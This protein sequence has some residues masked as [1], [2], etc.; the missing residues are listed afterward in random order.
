MA[1]PRM[2]QIPF[3]PGLDKESGAMV[4]RPG[5]MLDLRNVY[6][7]EGSLVVRD[8][9]EK[10]I[11]F[12]DFV[13]GE[14]ATHI[15]AGI[16]IRSERIGIVVSFYEPTG[17]VTI[18]RVDGTA[19]YGIPLGNWPYDVAV[20]GTET[21]GWPTEE[22]PKIVL[23]EIFGTVYFAHDERYASRRAPTWVY[24]PFFEFSDEYGL[25][26]LKVA[27]LAD[28]NLTAEEV[29]QLPIYDAANPPP[30]WQDQITAS[31]ARFRGVTRH[32]DYLVGWGWGTILEARPELVRISYPGE[33]RRFHADHYFIAGDRRDPVVNCKTARKTLL[34]FK[35]T[36]THR[37]KGYSRAT[38]GIEP[39]DNLY[40][41]LS[42]RLARTVTGE[43]FFWSAEGPRVGGDTGPSQKIHLPLDLGGF[44]PATLVERTDFEDG[45]C[46]YIDEVELLYFGFGRRLYVLS[47]RNRQDPRWT[48]WELARKAYTGFRLYG[49]GGGAPPEG[50]PEIASATV[51]TPVACQWPQLTVLIDN[52]NQTGEEYVQL[53][54]RKSGPVVSKSSVLAAS[55]YNDT[56][57][58]G[59]PDDWTVDVTGVVGGSGFTSVSGL[60]GT[61]IT[62]AGS[63]AVDDEAIVYVDVTD[64]IEEQKQYRFEVKAGNTSASVGTISG[65]R[66]VWLDSG[67]S[68]VNSYDGVYHGAVSAD[69]TERVRAFVRSVCPLTAVKARLTLFVKV[70]IAGGQQTTAFQDAGF[71]VETDNS[72]FQVPLGNPGGEVSLAAQ[73]QLGPVELTE[74]GIDYDVAVRYVN[75]GGIPTPGYENGS[76]ATWPTASVDSVAVTPPTPYIYL[77]RDGLNAAGKFGR[78]EIS[79]TSGGVVTRPKYDNLD[80]E[81]RITPGGYPAE[82]LG[83]CRGEYKFDAYV[84]RHLAT[85]I[86]TVNA[87]YLGMVYG[88]AWSPPISVNG[89]AGTPSTT[90]PTLTVTSTSSQTYTV[91][92]AYANPPAQLQPEWIKSIEVWDN[93]DDAGGTGEYRLRWHPCQDAL[94]ATCVNY[95]PAD[96]LTIN[97]GAGSGG[98]SVGVKIREVYAWTT[99]LTYDWDGYPPAFFQAGEFTDAETQVITT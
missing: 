71:Y 81:L 31:Y 34:V 17:H 72:W 9:M 19:D 44:E 87:R 73:Q 63:T 89:G 27:L 43:V 56:D 26:P 84:L 93:Y 13:T 16:A 46:D 42:G 92:W 3:G 88:S 7:H 79:C 20:D 75:L 15:L 48:Y 76:Q 78:L 86:N 12:T 40:G 10:K 54:L 23:A 85:G 61:S 45:W 38:F 24:D 58:D 47:L 80:L 60:T 5:S 8:G 77:T 95:E 69:P 97:L 55:L 29:A 59:E 2:I 49:F 96:P 83:I 98:V 4:V 21:L 6:H 68:V 1:D 99:F 14:D 66:L 30:A 64:G 39:Y 37:I 51:S 33:P 11:H 32:L 90:L 57:D 41:C 28:H 35:E 53:W 25:A 82:D 67:D 36:E 74:P 52:V 22:L 50:H 94:G 65:V 91:D 62:V 70:I 18:H